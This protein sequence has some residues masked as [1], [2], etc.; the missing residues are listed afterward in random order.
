M[1]CHKVVC[2][3]LENLSSNAMSNRYTSSKVSIN[4]AINLDENTHRQNENKNEDE[5]HYTQEFICFHK[6]GYYCAQP[7]DSAGVMA[8]WVSIYAGLNKID[9]MYVQLYYVGTYTHLQVGKI[10]LG[11]LEK[12]KNTI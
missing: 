11:S 2:N 1:I 3:Y 8:Y 12:D 5:K 7:R 4:Y 6:Q 10:E 9:R